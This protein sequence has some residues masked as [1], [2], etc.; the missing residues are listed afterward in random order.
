M[1][2]RAV[3]GL[4]RRYSYSFGKARTAFPGNIIFSTTTKVKIIGSPAFFFRIK[5]PV[6]SGNSK[7]HGTIIGLGG[8]GVLES[9]RRA[10]ILSKS[11]LYLVIIIPTSTST[12]YGGVKGSLSIIDG[13]AHIGIL[14]KGAKKVVTDYKGTLN[15]IT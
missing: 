10:G 9:L 4:S 6:S 11:G 7:I 3:R 2:S 14:F 15:I 13:N 5:N 1:S 8:R 12:S